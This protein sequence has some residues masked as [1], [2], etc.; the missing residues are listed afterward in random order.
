[1]RWVALRDL[2]SIQLPPADDELVQL[3]ISNSR[4]QIRI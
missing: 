3:L 4:G 1:M 2:P